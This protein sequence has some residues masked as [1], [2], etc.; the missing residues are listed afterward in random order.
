VEGIVQRDRDHQNVVVVVQESLKVEHTMILEDSEGEFLRTN[1]VY[2]DAPSRRVRAAE[3][4]QLVEK[5]HRQVEEA[6]QGISSRDEERSHLTTELQEALDA[7]AVAIQAYQAE[8]N[9]LKHQLTTEKEKAR[10]SWKTNCEHLAEQDAI[11]TAHE[12]EITALKAQ[13]EELRLRG[14]GRHDED[15]SLPAEANF[16]RSEGSGPPGES[17][18]HPRHRSRERSPSSPPEPVA[19]GDLPR[20]STLPLDGQRRRGKA[21]PIEVFSGEDPAIL[22]DDWLPSLERASQWNGWSAEDKLMQLPGYLCGRALQE[23]WLLSSSEQDSY[24][25]A[26]EALRQRLDPGSKTVAAQELRHS[27]QR[28]GE[29]VSDF[30]RCLQKTFQVAYGRDNLNTATRDALLYGQL[31]E[32]L[33]YEIMLSPAVSGSQGY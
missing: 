3:E 30:I 12:E 20:P 16:P 24:S 33:R 7:K 29:S 2:R 32:G 8:V 4:A 1:P 21:P 14:A 5:L 13:I 18:A 17:A 25:S 22:L 11:I 27:L 23:W 10:K 31:Y 6:E 28:G 15:G 26:I 19:E 9:S